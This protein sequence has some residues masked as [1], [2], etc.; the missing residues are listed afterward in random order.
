MISVFYSLKREKEQS[1][2]GR[3]VGRIW[4]KLGEGENQMHGKT[5]LK[6]GGHLRTLVHLWKGTVVG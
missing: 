1:W 5:Q 3:E 2:V 6:E 4:E